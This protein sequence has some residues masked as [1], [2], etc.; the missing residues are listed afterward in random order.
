VRK[1]SQRASKEFMY[2]QRRINPPARRIW[3]NIPAFS[4]REHRRFYPQGEAM[5]H[6]RLHQHR[7]LRPEGPELAFTTGCV[8]P[9]AKRVIR[10]AR[11][12]VESVDSSRRLERPDLT[13]IDRRIQF[14]AHRELQHA[15]AHRASSGSAVVLDV[16]TGEVLAMPTAH[17]NPNAVGGNPDTDRNRAITDVEPGSTM[18][19]LTVRPE[20]G[21]P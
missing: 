5:A 3:H 6:G 7:R 17:H 15:A 20:A 11:L 9:G 1:L 4:Q 8:A 21:S 13:T 16:A 10:D 14:L 19:P 12:T 18:K 2:P